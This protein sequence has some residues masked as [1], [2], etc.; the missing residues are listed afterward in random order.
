MNVLIV[1]GG[2]KSRFWRSLFASIYDKTIIQ[3]NVGQ[4]A[5]SLGAATV[6]AVACGLWDS[7]DRVRDI[8]T[9]LD[10][11]APDPAKRE[12]YAAML[13][14][15]QRIADLQSDVGDLLHALNV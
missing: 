2:G 1:G 14:V 15:F 5:G 7:Y 3:T 9:R 4:D 6:A 10:A 12:V 13:P 11:I 8:H